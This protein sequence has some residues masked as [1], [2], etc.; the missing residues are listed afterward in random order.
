MAATAGGTGVETP[1]IGASGTTGSPGNGIDAAAGRDYFGALHAQVVDA[2][3]YPRRARLEQIEGSVLLEM[4]IDRQGRLAH[5]AVAESSGSSLLDRH[6]L[7]V[8]RRAAPFGAVPAGL[9]NA[10]LSF[11]LPVEFQLPD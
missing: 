3:D 2:L 5:S 10:E 4:R 6:A 1:S 11:E 9:T 8:A 7:R